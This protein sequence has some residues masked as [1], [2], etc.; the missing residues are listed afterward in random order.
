MAL[1]ASGGVGGPSPEPGTFALGG[2][3][4]GLLLVARRYRGKSAGC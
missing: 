2:I 1:V 4:L 3:G